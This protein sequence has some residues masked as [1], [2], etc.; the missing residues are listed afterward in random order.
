MLRKK[1]CVHSPLHI[2]GEKGGEGVQLQIN[3]AVLVEKGTKT[4]ALHKYDQE[5]EAVAA[6]PAALQKTC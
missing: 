4:A 1:Q 5:D 6:A 2:N 3:T